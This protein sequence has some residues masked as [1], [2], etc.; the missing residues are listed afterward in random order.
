MPEAETKTEIP[1]PPTKKASSLDL[2]ISKGGPPGMH[3][4][5]PPGMSASSSGPPGMQAEPAKVSIRNIGGPPGMH[6]DDPPG[7]SASSSGPPGMQAEPAK[8]SKPA[9]PSNKAPS[10][11]NEIW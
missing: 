3:D 8:V 10:E 9:R 6:D 7:M 11:T 2:H 1:K 4:D 5:D